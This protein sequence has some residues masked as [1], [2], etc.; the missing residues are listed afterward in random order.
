MRLKYPDIPNIEKLSEETKNIR[1]KI[2]QEALKLLLDKSTPYFEEILLQIEM[3]K[4]HGF[5]VCSIKCEDVDVVAEITKKYSEAKFDVKYVN[6]V[7][8]I[9]WQI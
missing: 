7:L 8:Y 3:A 2:K 9:S 4:G 6:P 5:N 1:N